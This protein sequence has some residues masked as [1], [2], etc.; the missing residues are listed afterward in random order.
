MNKKI[1]GRKEEGKRSVENKIKIFIFFVAFSIKKNNWVCF[2]VRIFCEGF[3]F[4]SII[5]F[6]LFI[7][8]CSFTPQ[9]IFE[10]STN[11]ASAM[12]VVGEKLGMNPPLVGVVELPAAP[13]SGVVALEPWP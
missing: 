3:W 13:P 2:F 12:M 8:R 7:H 10:P 9:N 6:I 11:S 1:N 4:V 5:V